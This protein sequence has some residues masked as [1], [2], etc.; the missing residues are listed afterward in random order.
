[1]KIFRFLQS[2]HRIVKA[3]EPWGILLAVVG[4]GFTVWSFQVERVDREEDRINRAIGQFADG[5]G[6]IDALQILLRNDVNIQAL[7]AERAFLPGANLSGADL[8]RANLRG[9]ILPGADLRGANLIGASLSSANLSEASLSS[10]NFSGVDLSRA[11]LWGANLSEAVLQLANLS[12][13]DLSNANLSGADLLE[14]NLSRASLSRTDFEG[15][16]VQLAN[17]SKANLSAANLRGTDLSGA[18]LSRNSFAESASF[19]RPA[20]PVCELTAPDGSICYR[21]CRGTNTSCPWLNKAREDAPLP[22]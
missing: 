12:G 6:R 2:I 3:L 4:I 10:A 17:F 15:A 22:Q 20:G 9:S 13:A 16:D 21:Y 11:N 14:A 5:I 19:K 1:M 8:R 18:S 7:Q